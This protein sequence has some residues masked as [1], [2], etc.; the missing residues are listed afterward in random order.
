MKT[1]VI[2]KRV[3]LLGFSLAVM[4]ASAQLPSKITAESKD[5]KGKVSSCVETVY[6][7]SEVN[8]EIQKG[9]KTSE[10]VYNFDK[11]GNVVL[12]QAI[13][14]NGK[15]LRK[16]VY[17]Y[18]K[19]GREIKRVW[20][21]ASAAVYRE[22][23]T[24]YDNNMPKKYVVKDG[25]GK[26]LDSSYFEGNGGKI[27]VE[28]LYAKVGDSITTK[29]YNY[30][31]TNGYLTEKI[32]KKG[33]EAKIKE[34]YKYDAKGNLLQEKRYNDK[35]EL[36]YHYIYTY[37]SNGD[38]IERRSMSKSGNLSRIITY[39]YDDHG[40]MTEETWYDS[41]KK[42]LRMQK[43]TYTYDHNGNWISKIS[44]EGL[45]ERVIAITLRSIA[46]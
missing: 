26:M 30:T 13:G 37:N 7:A 15:T 43:F 6:K 22:Y 21:S 35:G 5:L 32:E 8:G 44:Y 42:I 31:Y 12:F 23:V 45:E 36:S 11:N 27:E 18:D 34:W 4:S 17:S 3:M 10:W 24:T 29:K 40:N 25:D 38:K 33:T 19:E 1:I 28:N 41:G 46:Y 9:D 14:G 16:Y 39:A 2:I 20:Y